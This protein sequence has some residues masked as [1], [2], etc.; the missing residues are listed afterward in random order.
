MKVYQIYYEE[1]QIPKLDYIPF[2]NPNCTVFF[3]NSVIRAL[4]EIKEHQNE[5]YFGVVSHQLREKTK[6]SK[7]AWRNSNI[8]NRSEIDFNPETF[9]QE[10]LKHKPDV[11]S[12]QRHIPHDPISHANKYHPNFSK[13]FTEIMNQIGFGWKPTVFQNVI[14]CNY[15]VAEPWI[16]ETYVSEM[17][18]PAMDIMKHMPEL[19]GNSGYSKKLPEPLSKSFGINHYPYHPFLCER[20]FSYFLHL[21]NYSCLHY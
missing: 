13:Y 19:Y 2:H 4:V 9:E 10:L 3:E 7:T 12:F 14:Y 17:L 18:A 21:N 1:S 11:M 6:L 16:Y 5:D 20:M 15:F 8:V